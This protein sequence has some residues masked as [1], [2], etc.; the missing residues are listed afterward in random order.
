MRRV[1][2]IL[3]PLII[4]GIALAGAH[5]LVERL[6]I[7]MIILLLFSYLF[8]RLGAKGLKGHLKTP[9]QHIQ[10]G[11][12]FQIE[13]VAE[14]SSFLP[15]PF[16]KLEI[17]TNR[18]SPKKD[19][20]I[21]LPS[22]GI[23]Y[24][25]N[26][27]SFPRRGRY[28]LGPLIS[29]TTDF[30]GLFRIRRKLDASKEILIYPSTVEL[31]FFQ[32]ES[33]AE[34]G[35]LRN[36]WLTDESSGAISGVREYAPGDSL[37]RI[38]WRS[39]AHKGKLIVKEF[40]F[41][42]AEKIWIILDLNKDLS[43]D[44]GAETIQEYSITIAASI[45]KKYADSGQHIGLIAHDDSYHFYPARP[46]YLNMWRI[47]ELLAVVKASG[48][49]PLNR[50][51]RGAREQMSGNSVAVI[52]TASSRDEIIDS[53]MSIKKRGIR[54]VTILLDA[55]TFGGHGSIQNIQ[56]RLRALN[57]PFYSV[58]QNDNLSEVLNSQE[59]KVSEV[60][61]IGVPYFAR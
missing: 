28:K 24:W 41:D 58:K 22:R 42:L 59:K 6:F 53:I 3:A 19:V 54:V 51:L 33:I 50:I 37:N 61:D 9:G 44:K 21:N 31:P 17:I 18:K 10:A 38:H 14:N 60:P 48:Q 43:Y 49:I 15:K 35:S 20:Q 4:L 7:L 52:I 16:L 2:L 36:A 55:S 12:P 23:Y 25:Q 8:A 30:L 56:M 34:S 29:E 39:T 32:A 1:F 40:D 5:I 13:A 57:L 46:G 11:Q 47:L 26:Y 27:I 45:V